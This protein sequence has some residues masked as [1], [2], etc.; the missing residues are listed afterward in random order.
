VVHATHPAASHPYPG[1]H[2]LPVL[3]Q[4]PLEPHPV[5]TP[6]ESVITYA[7]SAQEA[8]ADA[9]VDPLDE[10]ELGRHG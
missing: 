7:G 8:H 5:I 10:Y 2:G 3:G 9:D 4:L 1:G 6:L